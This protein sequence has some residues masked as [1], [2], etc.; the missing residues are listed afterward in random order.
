M[1]LRTCDTGIAE[2]VSNGSNVL[3]AWSDIGRKSY[4][5]L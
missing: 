4:S 5:S 2:I 3:S 1:Y